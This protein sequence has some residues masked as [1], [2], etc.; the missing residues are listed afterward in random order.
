V[1]CWNRPASHCSELPHLEQLH[2]IALAVP[3]ATSPIKLVVFCGERESLDK[4]K[5]MNAMKNE[6]RGKKRKRNRKK[7]T[8]EREK[9]KIEINY[10]FIFI[11][12]DSQIILTII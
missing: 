10:L 1:P 3:T 4:R 12:Y 6:G 2:T 5:E 7:K 11:N 8:K 9:I